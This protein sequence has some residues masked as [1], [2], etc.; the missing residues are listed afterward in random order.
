MLKLTFDTSVA[1]NAF[2]DETQASADVAPKIIAAKKLL[3]AANRGIV[4]IERNGGEVVRSDQGRL[5]QIRGPWTWGIEGFSEWGVSTVFASDEE[6][7]YWNQIAEIVR[8]P[9]D[10]VFDSSNREQMARVKDHILLVSHA[11]G[12]RDIFVT[13]DINHILKRRTEL[14]EIGI[15]VMTAEETVNYLESRNEI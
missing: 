13:E 3:E 11:G 14:A 7:V 2:E 15:L 5:K 10:N 12:K 9:T 1:I 6:I 8:L 4:E